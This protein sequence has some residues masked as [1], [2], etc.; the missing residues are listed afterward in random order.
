[1]KKVSKTIILSITFM[2]FAL[3]NTQAQEAFMLENPGKLFKKQDYRPSPPIKTKYSFSVGSS[4]GR[5]YLQQQDLHGPD[6]KIKSSGVF[7]EDGNKAGDVRYEY[8][9]D[10]MLKRSVYKHI[11]K[12]HQEITTYDATGKA[13]KTE[14]LTKTDSMLF[15]V[16]YTYDEND[17]LLEEQKFKGETLIS[18]QVYDDAYNAAGRRTQ[19]CHYMIDSSGARKPQN[20]AMTMME[21][22]PD[23]LIL[24]VTKYNNKEKRKMLSWVYYK[25]Q[26][27][28][29][30]KVIKQTGFDEEQKEIYRN[31]LSYTDS[32]IISDVYS[33]CD[34]PAKTI[35]K[36]EQR[37]L[38]FN[39]YGSKTRELIK[40]ANNNLISTH[41]WKYDDFGN[42]VEHVE[43]LASS[44][45]KL[46]KSKQILEF[47]AE[48][49][50]AARK[51]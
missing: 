3:A 22:D 17:H 37:I 27:D 29:D 35:D 2:A 19:L 31:E 36:K 1:M 51:K 33:M 18:K 24:Q 48:Q 44:P 49:A 15:V 45:D 13:D 25:Y 42:E 30:Y 34:C 47:K 50:Q 6:G 14:H 32:S 41:T 23:G 39:L 21:Y 16:R 12:D 28:N 4:S 38:V 46:I 20:A 9:A 43:V 7:S 26:L 10:G 40:D 5:E 11:G 8:S